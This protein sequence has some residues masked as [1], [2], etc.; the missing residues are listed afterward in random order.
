MTPI[1]SVELIDD[2]ELKFSLEKIG[3]DPRAFPYFR[4]KRQILTFRVRGVDS[5]AANILKQELLSRG[6][7]AAVHARCIDHGIEHTECLL[8]GTKKQLK[9]LLDK[10]EAMPY[11]GLPEIK[12]RLSQTLD[13]LNIRRFRLTLPRG[14]S[15]DL[16]ERTRIMGILNLTEESFYSGSRLSNE[17]QCLER[18]G[19]MLSA[20][21]DILDLG[22]ESTRPGATLIPADLEIERLLPSLR[23]IRE[24][25]PEAVISIDTNKAA[26]AYRCLEEG[27]D[28]INDISGLGFDEKMAETVARFSGALVMM[29]IQ[30]RPENM[31]KNPYYED[32]F[33]DIA[34]FFEERLNLAFQNG[35]AKDQIIL[36]PG[37]GFGKTVQHNLDLMR[38][39]EAFKGFG[40]PLLVGF[41]RK[42]TI[43][44]VLDLPDPKD[45]LEGTLALSALCAWKGIDIVRVHDVEPNFR[46]IKMVEAVKIGG[47]CR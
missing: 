44:S 16:G 24:T 41:S 31:Q 9:D 23:L 40:L 8:F 39:L 25:Y 38:H 19:Q 12:D 26:V 33:F 22:A 4:D 2:E 34:E 7:D 5:R 35:I 37:F 32:L 13:G 43:G 45:R 21:A 18:A 27:A 3:A 17:Q 1:L 46:V 42:S 14:R 6:G 36:D 20:G 11:W 47:R 10:L 30:G 28:I 29:H 15:L